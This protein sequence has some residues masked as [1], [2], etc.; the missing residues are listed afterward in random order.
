MGGF[1]S[2]RKSEGK[3]KRTVDES[4]TI[5]ISEFSSSLSSRKSRQILCCKNWRGYHFVF[6]VSLRH[7]AQSVVTIQFYPR[8]QSKKGVQQNIVVEEQTVAVC[9]RWWFRC[10]MIKD[11]IACG[12][13]AT[14]LHLP[15]SGVEFGCRECH[16][17]RYVSTQ[18]AH[19]AERKA[20]ANSHLKGLLQKAGKFD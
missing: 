20:K 4:C 17:L 13:R 2:G 1:G 16:D 9:N 19:K 11:D 15:Q 6:H 18:K 7:D 8:I 12:K 14:K 3:R 5:A 10:P